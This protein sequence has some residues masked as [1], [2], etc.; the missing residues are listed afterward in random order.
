VKYLIAKAHIGT[1]LVAIVLSAT[2]IAVIALGVTVCGS[3]EAQSTLPAAALAN[4]IRVS[5]PSTGFVLN[6]DFERL[7]FVISSAGPIT[8][9]GRTDKVYQG[10]VV[11]ARAFMSATI[12]YQGQPASSVIADA[13]YVGGDDTNPD[14]NDLIAMRCRPQRPDQLSAVLAT[15]P[16]VFTAAA[17]DLADLM[18]YTPADCSTPDLDPSYPVDQRAYCE[19]QSFS[20][21][22]DKMIPLSLQSAIDAGAAIFQLT[23]TPFQPTSATTGADVLYDLYGIGWGFSGLGFSVKDSYLKS[24]GGNV[25]LTAA[26]ALEQ[27]VVTEYLVKNV[28]LAAGNCRC[29][30]VKPYDDR[31]KRPLRWNAVWTKG[32]LDRGDFSCVERNRLP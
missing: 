1:R 20:D 30:R 2:L 7:F 4:S 32:L 26:R 5:D 12:L 21:Q 8:N 23:G 16:R 3:A 14:G 28:S 11:Q 27:S 13:H 19:S 17:S 29:V 25:P 22:A 18:G 24:N 6:Q 15:W 31:D 10:K 9:I